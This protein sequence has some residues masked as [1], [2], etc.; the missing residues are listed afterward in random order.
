MKKK[1]VDWKVGERIAFTIYSGRYRGVI[2]K[3]YKTHIIV[4]RDETDDVYHFWN[5]EKPIEKYKIKRLIKKKKIVG[6][7]MAREWWLEE[8]LGISL[9]G[10][11]L[12]AVRHTKP[13]TKKNAVVLVR[14]VLD[15]PSEGGE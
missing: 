8:I 12:F 3:V 9:D 14:E 13:Q 1:Q 10:K 2:V 11:P 15:E 4:F 6:K 7:R 5:I